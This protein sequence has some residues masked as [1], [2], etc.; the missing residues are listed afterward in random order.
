[1][2]YHSMT[3]AASTFSHFDHFQQEIFLHT[4]FF[5]NPAMKAH[6]ETK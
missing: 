3:D 2:Q 6:L 5:T 4:L 1:M